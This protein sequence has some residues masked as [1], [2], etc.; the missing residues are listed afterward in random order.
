[1]TAEWYSVQAERWRYKGNKV[2]Q[3]DSSLISLPPELGPS[4]LGFSTERGEIY[5][6][7]RLTKRT[8]PNLYQLRFVFVLASSLFFIANYSVP[9]VI[10]WVRWMLMRFAQ[11]LPVW[12]FEA[13]VYDYWNFFTQSMFFPLFLFSFSDELPDHHKSRVSRGPGRATDLVIYCTS[14]ATAL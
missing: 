4:D 13:D 2:A 10:W 14:H 5:C 11:D 12:E 9:L 1:M 6:F 8:P 7:D 3:T